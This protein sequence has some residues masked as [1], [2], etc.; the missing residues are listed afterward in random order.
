M[1]QPAAINTVQ[2]A[3]KK[4][5]QSESLTRAEARD[6][7]IALTDPALPAA[8]AG[9]ALVANSMN[10]IKAPELQGMADGMRVLA[11]SPNLTSVEHCVDIVGTGGDGAHSFNLSTG[12][13]LLLAAAGVPV[14]KHGNKAVSSRS[15][16]A[17]VLAALS[18][19]IPMEE[20]IAKRCYASAGFAFLFAP[21][22][23]PA[24]KS[25]AQVRKELGIRTIFNLLGP[26]TNPAQPTHYVLGAYSP[27]VA[28]IM[29]NAIQGLGVRRAFVIHS[30][31][32]WD[33]PTP[34]SRFTL[35][36]VTQQSIVKSERDH[37]D[38]GLQACSEAALKGGD[39]P[40]NARALT[41][42]FRGTH[43]DA[44]RDALVMG[45]SLGLEVTGQASDPS[46]AA[47]RISQVLDSGQAAHWLERLIA[48]SQHSEH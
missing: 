32:G 15:G 38:F 46:Q 16:S 21:H 31:N 26:L 28:E 44:H 8:L 43:K 34:A 48:G 3:L 36:D 41:E 14:I 37:R 18:I 45:A 29:A 40:V 12:A 23:H 17:D 27:A 22:Y 7:L 24:M 35:W 10:G 4:W 25:L 13:A 42:V 30:H 1:T 33:E 2:V 20:P 9:A 47:A 19:P 5:Q 39:A 6:V 11:K